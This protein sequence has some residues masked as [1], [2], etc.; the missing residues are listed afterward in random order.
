[1]RKEII[2]KDLYWRIRKR[3]ERYNLGIA[4][5]GLLLL[6]LVFYNKEIDL[7]IFL[8]I[9]V[10]FSILFCGF[11]L[12]IMKHMLFKIKDLRIII[13]DKGYS[14]FKPFL[15]KYTKENQVLTYYNF[16]KALENFNQ[17]DS[18][19]IDSK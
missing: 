16:L 2:V 12:A 10:T 19:N 15:K 4:I 6:F 1:M 5:T 17:E 7:P 3:N 8:N 11:F 9:A 14:E 18:P 13:N